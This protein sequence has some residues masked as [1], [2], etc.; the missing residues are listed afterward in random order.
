[1]SVY[2]LS[3][4]STIDGT[5]FTPEEKQHIDKLERMITDS[6]DY[7]KVYREAYQTISKKF[8]NGEKMTEGYFHVVRDHVKKYYDTRIAE[9]MKK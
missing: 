8:K 1:M 3:N 6:E 5:V 2:K 7:F 4:G 9:V